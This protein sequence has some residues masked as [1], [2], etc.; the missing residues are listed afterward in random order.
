MH[1]E[2]SRKSIGTLQKKYQ[3]LKKVLVILL[4]IRKA[5]KKLKS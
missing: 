1:F 2:T 3:K 4:S 5:P